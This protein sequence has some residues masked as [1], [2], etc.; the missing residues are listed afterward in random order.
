[1][2]L[3]RW[4]RR[5][6][7]L[8][9]LVLLLAGCAFDGPRSTL[10]PAGEVAEIQFWLMSYTFWLSVGVMVLVIGALVYALVKFRARPTDRGIPVQ[11]HGSVGVEAIWT[12]IPV[13][14]VEV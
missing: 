7:P 2:S 4:L 1:M 13:V 6:G 3:V 8:A 9:G 12:F 11:T 5:F 10:S 14:I